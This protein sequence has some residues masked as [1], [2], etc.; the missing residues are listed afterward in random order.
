MGKTLGKSYE[1]RLLSKDVRDLALKELKGI[2][3]NKIK[4]DKRFRQAIILKLAGSVLPRLNEVTGEDGQPLV[5]KFDK[6]FDA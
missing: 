3:T 5:V 1:S 4:V 6:S 2:L